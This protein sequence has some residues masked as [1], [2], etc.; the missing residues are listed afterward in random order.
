MFSDVRGFTAISETYKDDPQGLTI[1]LNR[2]LTPLTNCVIER[3]GTIDK[4]IGDGIMAFW[5]APLDD[6]VHE[7][8]AC[9][10]ALDMLERVAVLNAERAQEAEAA[11]RPFFPLEIGIGINTGTCFVGNFGSD[12]HFNYSV[13]GDTVNVSSRLESQSK[14]YGLPIIIGARTASAIADKMAVLELDLLQVVGKTKPERIFTVLGG[15]EL[16]TSAAFREITE[17]QGSMLH[18]YRSRNWARALEINLVCRER[19][20]PFG[21]N[22]YYASFVRRILELIDTPPPE[23]WTGVTVREKK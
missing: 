4:Y 18:A 17:L 10:A 6:A 7:V 5:N 21:L 1:L 8:N 14:L 9:S 16:R 23:E 12:L 22:E 15:P 11:N 20:K 13:L 2:L 3:S 19:G